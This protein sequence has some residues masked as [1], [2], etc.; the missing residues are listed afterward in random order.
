MFKIKN[1][2]YN[3]TLTLITFTLN[4]KE[5]KIIDDQVY[6]ENEVAIESMK[7]RKYIKV[8]P[9]KEVN[10]SRS[11]KQEVTSSTSTSKRGRK[12]KSKKETN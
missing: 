6:L 1:I 10:I 12:S 8:L 3:S 9:Y 11:S 2:T 5:T 4:P 7:R